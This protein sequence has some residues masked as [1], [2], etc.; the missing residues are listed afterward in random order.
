MPLFDNRVEG[1]EPAAEKD[2]QRGGNQHRAGGVR[3]GCGLT[4]GCFEKEG[5]VCC[6]V[7]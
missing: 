4:G 7:L 6:T 2:Q 1:D 3:G 5:M